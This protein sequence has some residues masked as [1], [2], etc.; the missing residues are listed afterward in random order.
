M[1]K[2]LIEDGGVWCPLCGCMFL[3][4]DYLRTVFVDVRQRWLANMVTHHRHRH[5]SYYDN[6]VGYVSFFH[7]Y[8]AF[9]HL[10][11][12]RAK[13]QIL[14]KCGEFMRSHGF[15]IADFS[16]LQG[17]DEKTLN[18]AKDLLG[19]LNMDSAQTTLSSLSDS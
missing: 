6:G 3:E 14:R 10:A 19:P 1:T 17:T 11:N 2:V 8:D 9:K 15:T 7:D 13:R 4:S 18:L 16:A 5:V 12:E